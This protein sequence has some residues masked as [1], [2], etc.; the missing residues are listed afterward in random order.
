MSLVVSV[1]PIGKTA[2]ANVREIEGVGV[3]LRYYWDA[4]LM[5]S[6]LF[7]DGTDV[8]KE[9]EIKRFDLLERGWT[10]AEPDKPRAKPSSGLSQT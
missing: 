2:R 4:E 7:N 10:P 5:Q 8:L 6:F 9:A 1:W 3:E